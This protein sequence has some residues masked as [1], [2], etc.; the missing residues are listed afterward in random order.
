MKNIL[1]LMLLCGMSASALAEA[2]SY[3]QVASTK[4]RTEPKLWSSAMADLRFGN[5]VTLLSTDENWAKVR[6]G[7]RE[8]FLPLSAL[9][10][11]KIQLGSEAPG[12]SAAKDD[13][14]LAGKGF[15]TNTEEQFAAT[16]VDLN[17]GEVDRLERI[18]IADGQLRSF[19]QTGK[20][21]QK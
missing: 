11:K 4:L 9:S 15:D 17:Y 14:I 12:R 10:S 8:G 6:V 18:R 1:F 7:K 2:V 21:S 16:G 19:V 13:V 3:V 20:L 5:E